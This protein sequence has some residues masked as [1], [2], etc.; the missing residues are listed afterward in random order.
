MNNILT[1]K[2][3]ERSEADYSVHV[4]KN[5]ERSS[6]ENTVSLYRAIG[7]SEFYSVM[8]TNKFGFWSRSARV[9]YFAN[10]FDEALMFANKAFATDIVAVLEIRV[11]KDILEQIGDFTN[12]D[13][14]LFRNGTVEIQV[15]HL[16]EFNNSI[17]EIIH[18]Y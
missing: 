6:T 16:E 12:V 15:E 18:R 4:E 13:T 7:E 5:I 2:E 8:R 9:K 1:N 14:T 11:R 3:E 10:S 17:I